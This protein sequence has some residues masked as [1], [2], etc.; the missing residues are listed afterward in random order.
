M[1]ILAWLSVNEPKR[2][3]FE[4]GYRN[5]SLLW[6]TLHPDPFLQFKPSP[7]CL[8]PAS[9]VR[10]KATG[11]VQLLLAGTIQLESKAHRLASL[12]I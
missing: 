12:E 8:P 5:L 3:K 11:R 4:L 6:E 7:R 9:P 2:E 1:K 10:P